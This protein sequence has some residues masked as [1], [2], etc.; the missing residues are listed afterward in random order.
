MRLV[1]VWLLWVMYILK[2]IVIYRH[3]VTKYTTMTL[4]VMYVCLTSGQ[5]IDQMVFVLGLH[6]TYFDYAY[7]ITLFP[8]LVIVTYSI[9]L[10]RR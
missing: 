3:P 9:Y 8:S 4:V 6:D 2:G 5:F 7:V 1:S 10:S